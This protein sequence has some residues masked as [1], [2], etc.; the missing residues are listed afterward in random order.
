MFLWGMVTWGQIFIKNATGLHAARFF[1]GAMEGGYIPGFALYISKYYTNQELALRYAIFWASNNFAGILGG[2][3]SIG[4]LFLGGRHGLRGWQWLFL[5]E[6][7]LTSFL[8]IIAYIYLPHSAAKPKTFFKRS[9]S[10]FTPREASILT[11]RVITNDP[12][13]AGRS[14]KRV[15]PSDVLETFLDWRI[16][17]HIVSGFLSM[18]MISPVNTY[19]PSIIKD[20]G[21][22]RLQANGLNSVGR[23]WYS[24]RDGILVERGGGESYGLKWEWAASKLSTPH[25]S[26]PKYKT[27]SDLSPWQHAPRYTRG[28]IIAASCAF[29]AT[30]VILIWKVFYRIFDN[31]DQGVEA[32]YVND[33]YASTRRVESGV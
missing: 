31:G 29:A 32:M 15:S 14:R 10:L 11:T 5:I 16:Y 13:K 23:T 17:G 25:G 1:I 7:I 27:I 8:G 18:V 6:G 26:Q 19:A 30:V 12:S 2:P 24:Y 28:L 33:G 3:L 22:T 21:F 20:L 9:F 4:L